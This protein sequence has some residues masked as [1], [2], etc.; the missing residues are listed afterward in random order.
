LSERAL[1]GRVAIVGQHDPHI[2]LQ[3]DR[4]PDNHSAHLRTFIISSYVLNMNIPIDTLESAHRHSSKHQA[5]IEQSEICACFSCC[6]SFSASDIDEWLDDED[7]TALCP[8]CGIDA[9]IG[10]A[11]GFPVA[12]ADFICAMHKHWFN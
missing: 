6:K 9:V 10:S 2:T 1:G 7:G 4:V 3:F 5:E 8:N 12:D 11:S